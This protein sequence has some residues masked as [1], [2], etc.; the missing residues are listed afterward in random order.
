MFYPEC[1]KCGG[2]TGPDGY[3]Q[4][5]DAEFRRTQLGNRHLFNAVPILHLG[6]M[7]FSVGR[8]IYKRFPGGGG[9][10]CK[11]CYHWFE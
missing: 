8:Q 7:L 1:P 6:S 4:R 9:K 5:K 3:E 10:R 11:S 2:E